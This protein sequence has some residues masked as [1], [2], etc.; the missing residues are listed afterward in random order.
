MTG[1]PPMF[2]E[3]HKDK[4]LWK[5]LV[6]QV[7]GVTDERVLISSEFFSEAKAGKVRRIVKD[8]G[9]DQVH[10]VV[11]LRPLS[12]V[13][14]AQWQQYVQ[15]GLRVGYEEWL[16]GLFN[17][18]PYTWPSPTFWRR[19]HQAE[20]VERWARVVGPENTT[21][22]AIDDSDREMLLRSFENLLDLPENF[23][24][25]DESQGNRSLSYGETELLRNFNIQFKGSGWRKR[26]YG[27]YV[28]RGAVRTMKT[29]Y[30]P[31]RD[32]AV[33][34]TPEWA[35]QRAAKL[36]AESAETIASLGVRVVGD[37]TVLEEFPEGRV[38]TPDP[39]PKVDSR[40]AAHAV[41]GAIAASGDQHPESVPLQK[42]RLAYV[43]T[44]EL[45]QELRERCVKKIRSRF[46][47]STKKKA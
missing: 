20:L 23:L 42:R 22:I 35:V 47:R 19:H 41:F 21:V 17:K 10:I 32:E 30:Q 29:A 33:I 5:R 11:T 31:P 38:G 18:P 27:P 34:P 15:S 2:G 8:M 44:R 28:R 43:S 45:T 12:K 13:L 39:V 4:N 25:P 9:G 40:A 7:E 3:V 26:L 36:G 46:Q 1:R 14:P 16:D 24:V 6:R 37:L